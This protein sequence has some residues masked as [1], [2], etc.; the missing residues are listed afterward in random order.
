M[1]IYLDNAATTPV[2]PQ[3]AELMAKTIREDFGNPSSTHSH[4]VKVRALVEEARKKVATLLG[5]SPGEIFF[6]SGGTEADN[7]AIRCS[8]E[9]LGVHHIISSKIE[10]H[11]VTHTLEDMHHRRGIGLSY[12]NI[13]PNGYIEMEH[14]AQ[15]MAT[16]PGSLVS[17]MHANNELGNMIDID[18]VAALCTQ[19]RC[20][21][22]CDTVQTMG[23][24]PHNFS[25]T[26][27]SFAAGAAHKFNGPKGVGFIYINAENKIKPL[28]TG[29]AQERNMRAGT[30]NVYGI[31]GL[32]KALEL[33]I[34][35]MQQEQT[36]I[37][38]LKNH[39]MQRLQADIPG[40]LFNGDPA[41]HSLYTVLNV[42]LPPS[43]Y[44]EMMLFRLDL[45]GI[46]CSGGSACSSGS[47]VGSHVLA[48]L[49][50]PENRANV[51]FSF[52]SQNTL[53]EIN[54]VVD[55]LKELLTE[56]V[57]VG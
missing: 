40:V 29:G 44:T 19:H 45:E 5:V 56:Q 8:V 35:N 25:K 9:D 33:A 46:S 51:R 1:N 47:Q 38:N 21:F 23:H 50:I 36:H 57:A 31:V 11:A 52:G 13:T 6:T 55:K 20:W 10:H 30:E 28:L 3:V 27:L 48:E 37:L 7:M 42:S 12:V 49:A 24:Y 34:Q 18:Q 32:A 53:A 43:P 14:L 39:M 54:Y 16:H 17:L 41:G 26:K 4:G 2:H 22:H 15:L